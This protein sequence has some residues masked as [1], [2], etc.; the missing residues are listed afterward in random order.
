MNALIFAFTRRG[1]DT[2][3][4]VRE[5]VGGEIR[6]PRRLEA[7]DCPAY[8]GSLSDCVG[9]GFDRDALVFVGAAGIAVRAVAPFVSDKLSDP[10]VLC[11]DERGQFVVPLL[12]GHIGGANRLARQIASALGA[13][14]V[15]TTAT[16]VNGRFSVDAWASERGFAI[17][18]MALA[19]RVSAEI[20][21]REIP[22]CADG[23]VSG[24]LP[25]GLVPGDSGPLGIC[26]ST[27]RLQPFDA[28]LLLAPKALRVGIGCRR[29][30]PREA[31]DA[32][33]EAVFAANGLNIEAVG[34]VATIDRKGDEPGLVDCCRDR[35]WPLKLYT[36]EQ[37]EAVPGAFSDS[38]FVRAAVGVG[39]VC[40]RAAL[41]EGGRL[42][43][44]KTAGDGVT[45]AVAEMKWG[46][47]FGEA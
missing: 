38:E 47:D 7:G 33:I 15:I 14:P 30:T 36:A 31:I 28:T 2:A 10:A 21:T 16:D 17:S 43:V 44:P 9:A 11:L 39:N 18:D 37:L 19:K 12:S 32:R 45:V 23:P 42:V 22:F 34:A 24:E 27:R 35:G 13:T 3:R 8:A 20:L 6:V 41:A 46:I 1:I 40:E 5:A 29:G 25:D 26:A 4:R